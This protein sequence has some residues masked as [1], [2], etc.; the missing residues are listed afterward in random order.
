MCKTRITVEEFIQLFTVFIIWFSMNE[1]TKFRFQSNYELESYQSFGKA[2]NNFNLFIS[3]YSVK[4][5]SLKIAGNSQDYFQ[6]KMYERSR[7][8][9]ENNL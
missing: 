9:Q 3:I 8:Y 1:Y 5:V 6:V 7:D 2:P 4:Y